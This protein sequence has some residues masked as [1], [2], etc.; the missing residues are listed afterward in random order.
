MSA[1]VPDK[2]IAIH[3]NDLFVHARL[4]G[5]EEPAASTPSASNGKRV[6][7]NSDPL[8]VGDFDALEQHLLGLFGIMGITAKG[9]AVIASQQP[10]IPKQKRE[11][12]IASLFE[13]LG[14]EKT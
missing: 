6:F 1:A 11:D 2:P 4:A 5:S 12:I 10:L 8:I 3:M 9:A 7:N 13:R 14:A